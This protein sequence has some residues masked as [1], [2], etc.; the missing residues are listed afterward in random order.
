[1]RV[2]VGEPV[3]HP[4]TGET[5]RG[6]AL[7]VVRPSA[8]EHPR[9]LAVDTDLHVVTVDAVRRDGASAGPH[10]LLV[11]DLGWKLVFPDGHAVEI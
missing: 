1:M 4:V 6:D 5:L 9:V 10:P 8:G 3:V 11:R 2:V 7:K